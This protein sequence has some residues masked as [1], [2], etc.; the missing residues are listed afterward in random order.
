MC[1]QT[2]K[3]F[4]VCAQDFGV[5]SIDVEGMEIEVLKDILDA[6]YNPYYI[7]MEKITLGVKE[8][9]M[10]ELVR[11][12]RQRGYSKLA[13]IHLNVIFHADS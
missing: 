2:V 8:H 4:V 5:L 6:G 11:N 12:M 1:K 9:N 10:E 13:E 3:S 7:V